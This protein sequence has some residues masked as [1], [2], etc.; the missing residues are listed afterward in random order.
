[1]RKLIKTTLHYFLYINTF[2]VRTTHRRRTIMDKLTILECTDQFIEIMCA[3]HYS[4]V[5]KKAIGNASLI[6]II[7]LKK[8][9]KNILKTLLQSSTQIQL[10]VWN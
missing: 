2:S 9:T 6:F 10:Q 1:M 7:I 5:S 4:E 3:K 8:G